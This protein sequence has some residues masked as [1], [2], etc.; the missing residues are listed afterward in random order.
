M[1]AGYDNTTWFYE[2]LSKVVFGQAQVKAQEY[3]LNQIKP[4]SNLLI[5]GGGTGQIL[6]S[7]NRLHHS[8]LNIAY[9]EI[10]P[11]MMALS[12]KRNIGQN[13]VEFITDDIARITFT[14]KFDVVITAFL[15]DNFSNDALA[16]IFPQI[17]KWVK[18][19]GI[20]LNTDF[21]LTG[22]LWQKLML[23]SMYLFFKL[24]KAVKVT[25]LPNTRKVFEQYGYHQ[26][27]EKLYYG[28]FIAARVYTRSSRN[29]NC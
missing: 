4:Q 10:S 1:A 27:N 21:Q 3:F 15:F 18:Q 6:E 16:S 20:W 9:V 29:L 17:D 8:G 28:S 22:P 12:R 19:G 2:S 26:T 14:H 7:I 23:K 13:K 5:I 11:K 25:K 24:M